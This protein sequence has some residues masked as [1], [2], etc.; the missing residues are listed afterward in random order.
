MFRVITYNVHQW[1]DCDG[2]EN[3]KGMIETMKEM[4]GDIIGLQEVMFPHKINNK[5]TLEIVAEKLNFP[6]FEFHKE[7]NH[8]GEEYGNA[9]LSK[10]PF[11]IVVKKNIQGIAG[12]QKFLKIF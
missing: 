9:F 1:V 5:T 11:K 8:L 4:R 2:K 3:I 6:Y 12:K 10:F 7:I